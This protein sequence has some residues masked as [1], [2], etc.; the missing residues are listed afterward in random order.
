MALNIWEVMLRGS[1]L[2]TRV[3]SARGEAGR[4]IVGYHGNKRKNSCVMKKLDPPAMLMLA[5]VALREAGVRVRLLLLGVTP[6]DEER[7]Y[8]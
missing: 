7:N 2:T 6:R 8:C 4:D 3:K 5:G 1:A